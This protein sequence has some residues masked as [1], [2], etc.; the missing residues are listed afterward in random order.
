MKASTTKGIDVNPDFYFESLTA[1]TDAHR[2][3]IASS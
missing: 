2:A 3:E 1:L